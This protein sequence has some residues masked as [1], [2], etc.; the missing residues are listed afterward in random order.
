MNLVEY[1]VRKKIND[2]EQTNDRWHLTVTL[3]AR[4]PEKT[5]EYMEAR[6]DLITHL[7]RTLTRYLQRKEGLRAKDRQALE[8]R[9]ERAKKAGRKKGTKAVKPYKSKAERLKYEIIPWVVSPPLASILTLEAFTDTRQQ[10]QAERMAHRAKATR[11]ALVQEIL[12]DPTPRCEGRPD[13][14]R[15]LCHCCLSKCRKRKHLPAA[16]R[17]DQWQGSIERVGVGLCAYVG[18]HVTLSE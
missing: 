6:N 4:D 17:L 5:E 7:Q 15:L 13:Q 2:I 18:L 11:S 9:K 3:A 10:T 14:D 16:V 1:E 12:V 8:E